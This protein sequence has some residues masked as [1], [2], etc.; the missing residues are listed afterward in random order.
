MEKLNTNTVFEAAQFL[1]GELE[2]RLPQVYE[3][4]YAPLWA[5]AAL[6][7]PEATP[8]E[9]GSTSVVEEIFE[10]VGQAAEIEDLTTDVPV[11]TAAVGETSYNV[12]NYAIA[13]QYSILQ[14]AR[15]MKS[16]RSDFNMRQARAVDRALRQSV[17][18]LLVFGSAKRGSTGL[19]NDANIPTSAPAY[20]PNTATFQQHVNFF[21]EQ[22]TNVKIN[23]Q[24]AAGTNWV[25]TSYPHVQKLKSTY[26]SNDSGLTAYEAIMK[27]HGDDGL[28][29]IIGV[30]ECR[31][32][33]LEQ[34]GVNTVGDDLDKMVFLPEDDMVISHARYAPSFLP[35]Q[36]NK[37]Q[38]DVWAYMGCSEL[39]IHA[40]QEM[41][42][43]D[44][45]TVDTNF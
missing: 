37:M 40:P 17:H 7:I 14:L 36:P 6:Y 35:P 15:M 38:F 42:Y 30:N 28:Q 24:L 23:N 5:E 20:N 41:R 39:I 13:Y 33:L 27:L 10:A 2:Q 31:A 12:H 22:L 32:D 1:E 43:V 9:I 25:L 4:Q 34:F 19:L 18:E 45:P 16:G 44:I 11:V 8:L 26:Q 3:Q 21:T 29:G